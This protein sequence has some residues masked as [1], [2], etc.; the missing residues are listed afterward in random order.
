VE[1]LQDPGIN[2]GSS[3]YLLFPSPARFFPISGTFPSGLFHLSVTVKGN[4]PCNALQGDCSQVYSLIFSVSWSARTYE[5]AKQTRA[6]LPEGCAEVLHEWVCVFLFPSH[7]LALYVRPLRLMPMLYAIPTLVAGGFEAT[8]T[9]QL[10]TI[11]TLYEIANA[12]VSS[13][14][15]GIPESRLRNAIAILAKS[16]RAQLI[17]I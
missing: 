14:L 2:R 4:F 1:E 10:N 13:V 3:I 8:S 12:P 6:V 16:G 17:S 11:L 15:S 5:P 7:L 9:G